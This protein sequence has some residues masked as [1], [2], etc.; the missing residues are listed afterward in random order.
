MG[1][2]LVIDACCLLNLLASTLEHEI[3]EARA[4]D[5]IGSTHLR[6]EA[7]YLS[8]PPDE[9]GIPKKEAIDLSHLETSGAL[10]I[11]EAERIAT[12]PFIRCAEHLNDADAAAV[13]L[14]VASQAPLA[15]DDNR[16]RNVTKR[17]Y[18]EVELVSTLDLIRPAFEELHLSLEAQRRCARDIR[19]RASFLPPKRDPHRN[20]FLELLA[21]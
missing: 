13:A 12:G 11:E 15:T 2:S 19:R 8:G 1:Q 4:L 9:D 7:L 10:R 18:P 20:W 17:M 14:A 21:G 6:S 3:I 16:Q 5:L